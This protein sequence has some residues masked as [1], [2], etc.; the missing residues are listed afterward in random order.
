M[1]NPS[2]SALVVKL[3]ILGAVFLPP[4]LILI[5]LGSHGF[6]HSSGV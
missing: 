1:A 6:F 3:Q 2:R 4:L 5:W